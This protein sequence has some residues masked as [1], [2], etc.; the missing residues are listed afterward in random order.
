MNKKNTINPQVQSMIDTTIN[1]KLKETFASLSDGHKSVL[2]NQRAQ[3]KLIAD[4]I[5][6]TD[7]VEFRL[8]KLEEFLKVEYVEEQVSGYRKITK[9]KK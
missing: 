4:L 5:E 9:T 8:S 3:A 7:G 6:Y 1:S 2:G